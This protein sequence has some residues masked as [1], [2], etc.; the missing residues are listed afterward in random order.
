MTEESQSKVCGADYL[1]LI[2]PQPNDPELWTDIDRLVSSHA[3]T[4]VEELRGMIREGRSWRERLVGLVTTVRRGGCGDLADLL[5]CLRDPHGISIVAACAA[6]VAVREKTG[7]CAASPFPKDLDRKAFDGE[8]GWALDKACHHL[9]V[10]T[11]DPGG[12]GPNYGQVF[13]D[14]LETYRR[15]A[16]DAG[17]RPKGGRSGVES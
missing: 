14:H 10:G 4:T 12:R 15:L 2:H 7:P 16:K 5:H 8:L 1:A 3:D 13:E 11:P 6:Y 17:D 9:G